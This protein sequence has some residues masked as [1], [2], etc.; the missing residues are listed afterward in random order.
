MFYQC[1]CTRKNIS[2]VA[3]GEVGHIE[4]LIE[5]KTMSEGTRA[6][7]SCLLNCSNLSEPCIFRSRKHC[8]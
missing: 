4:T 5:V 2:W 3:N 1:G 7:L 8:S 6:L